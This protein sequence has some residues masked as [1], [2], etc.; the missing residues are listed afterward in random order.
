MLWYIVSSPCLLR[1]Y[2]GK[3]MAH[4]SQSQR[5]AP[6]SKIHGANISRIGRRGPRA[7]PWWQNFNGT[8]RSLSL[9]GLWKHMLPSA[10]ISA[11]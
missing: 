6:D 10:K 3:E 5:N 4:L 8:Q 1:G 2:A 11:W 9:P 7:P